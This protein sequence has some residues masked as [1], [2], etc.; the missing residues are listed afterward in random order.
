MRLPNIGPVS[1][2]HLDMESTPCAKHGGSQGDDGAVFHSPAFLRKLFPP[3]AA[4]LIRGHAVEEQDPALLLLLVGELVGH[5]LLRLGC[6][7]TVLGEER[8][9]QQRGEGE[10]AKGLQGGAPC[11]LVAPCVRGVPTTRK[12]EASVG[13]AVPAVGGL[14]GISMGTRMIGG[15]T[16]LIRTR[17]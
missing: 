14:A 12:P 6:G 11:R 15:V 3:V 9:A 8:R 5:R 7:P 1:R 4:P 13:W 16:S 10:G 17:T 2:W